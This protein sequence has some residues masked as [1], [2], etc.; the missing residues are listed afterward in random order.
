[1]TAIKDELAAASKII[2]DDELIHEIYAQLLAYDTRMEIYDEDEQQQNPKVAGATTTSY[3][4]DTNCSIFHTPVYALV[5][6]TPS[7]T[8]RHGHLLHDKPI[9]PMCLFNW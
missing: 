2:D 5:N 9:Y 1:M 8:G 7:R 3:G 4:V 6:C